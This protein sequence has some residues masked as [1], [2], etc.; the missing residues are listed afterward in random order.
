MKDEGDVWMRTYRVLRLSCVVALASLALVV[1][2]ETQNIKGLRVLGYADR[3]GVEPGETIRFMVSSEVPRFRADIVRLIHGDTNP[4]GPGFKEELIDA[5][6]NKEYPGKFQPF[7]NGSYGIVPDNPGLRLNGSFTLQAWINATTPQKGV[8]GILTKYSARD[9]LGYGL[10]LENGSLSLWIGDGTGRVEKVSAGRALQAFPR[11]EW[12]TTNVRRRPTSSA[13]WTFVA[14]SFDA[15]T[16]RVTIYQEPLTPWPSDASGVVTE[17][18]IQARAVGQSDAPLL[19]AGYWEWR[20]AGQG[21]VGGFY[22]GKID[23]PRIFDRVLS[24]EDIA[25]LK[26]D[27]APSDPVAAWDFSAD[28]PTERVTDAGKNG[29]HGELVNRPARAVTGHNFSGRHVSF[30]AAPKEYGAIHFHDDDLDDAKWDVSFEYTI[31]ASLKSGVYAARL[32][33]GNGEDYVVFFV[34]PK[35]GTAT[36]DIALLIP[37]VSYMAYANSGNGTPELLSLYNHHSDGSGVMYSSMLRPNLDMRPKIVTRNQWQ[38]VADTHITDWLEAKKFAYDVIT[39][40]DLHADG[41]AALTPY[42]VVVTGTHPEYYSSQML[43]GTKAYLEGGGRV[44]Y[45]G[46]NGYYWVTS[47]TPDGRA[48]EVRRNHGTQAWEGMPGEHHHATTGEMGGLWRFRGRPPQALVGVGFTAQGFDKNAP[49][50]RAPGSFDPRATWIFE[51]VGPDEVI[52]NFPSLVLDWGAAGSELDRYDPQLGSPPD[53][54][55]LASS[56]PSDYT[57]AYQHVVEEIWSSN[58]GPWNEGVTKADMVFFDYPNGGAVWTSASIAWSGSLSYNNYMNN[59]SRITENVL[60]GFASAQ[61]LP[62]PAQPPS[63]D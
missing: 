37:T 14:A 61:P 57:A 62:R 2:V 6:V 58:S 34:R 28:I 31:P 19:M 20:E 33:A 5:P 3:L 54:L 30:A 42:K 38:F 41:A 53:A 23:S 21:K 47:L 63:Q 11:M 26:R 56:R 10:F 27:G 55:V 36:A 35:K 25:A 17:R 9:R 48:V 8:Q 32:R 60:R 7:P 52:G 13:S 44:M 49:Y 45:M 59:V 22:N 12:P 16:G 24:T 4:R 15:A 18:T 50:Y 43:D 39:D 51:G 46:G 29:F 1:P 40:H